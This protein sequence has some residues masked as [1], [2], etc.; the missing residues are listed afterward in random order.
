MHEFAHPVQANLLQYMVRNLVEHIRFCINLFQIHLPESQLQRRNGRFGGIPFSP[1]FPHEPVSQIVKIDH[2]DDLLR[3]QFETGPT[4]KT[5]GCFFDHGQSSYAQV[6]VLLSD[7]LDDFSRFGQGGDGRIAQVFMHFG[8]GIEFKHA[9]SIAC[10]H[11]THDQA[12]GF[13]VD[14]HI[15]TVLQFAAVLVKDAEKASWREG[16]ALIRQIE[17]AVFKSCLRYDRPQN[18]G[19]ILRGIAF[20]IVKENQ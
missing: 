18:T 17:V 14:V 9:R 3:H 4:Y 15:R 8:I 7:K 12:F 6:L 19:L 10:Y 20:P 1:M 5:P 2:A 13:E 11:G 16:D